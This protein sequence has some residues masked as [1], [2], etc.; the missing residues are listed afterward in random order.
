MATADQIQRLSSPRLTYRHT[1]K[2]TGAR[3]EDAVDRYLDR[4][5]LALCL[6]RSCANAAISMPSAGPGPIATP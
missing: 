5:I 6:P 2:E 1:F 3:R 4:D